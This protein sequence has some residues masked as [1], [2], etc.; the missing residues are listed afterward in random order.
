MN[1]Y[2]AKILL[3]EDEIEVSEILR[4]YLKAEGFDVAIE[5]Q[6]DQV[7]EKVNEFDPDLILLDRNLPGAEGLDICQQLRA[8]SDVAIIMLTAKVDEIDRLMGYDSGADDY[9]CK[10][11]P[12]KEV[13]ARVKAVLR[14]FKPTLFKA[15]QQ[16]LRLDEDHLQAF[17]GTNNLALTPVEFRILKMLL[18]SSK[19]MGS[20]SNLMNAA[21][22]DGRL[23][24]ERTIDSHVK[25]LRAKLI[26]CSKIDNPIRSIYGVGYQ[27]CIEH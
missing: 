21:Y 25:N 26:N 23:V 4:D 16:K 1:A 11:T 2:K 12:P 17:W 10:P 20:R 3:V 7:I 9:I 5:D 15:D 13:I 18:N 27:L 8:T 24:S 19:G 22:Q 6:G 14:R